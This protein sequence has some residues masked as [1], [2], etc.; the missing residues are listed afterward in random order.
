MK[1]PPAITPR[2]WFIREKQGMVLGRGQQ[3]GAEGTNA[4]E[5]METESLDTSAGWLI[6]EIGITVNQSKGAR[7]KCR[8]RRC[9]VHSWI[10]NDN[11]TMFK[12][13]QLC[14]P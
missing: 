6:G 3:T 11:G 12:G 5:S 8:L 9:R 7:K 1:L 14:L 2:D 10:Q 13:R 4:R